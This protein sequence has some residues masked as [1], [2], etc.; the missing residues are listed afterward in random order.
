RCFPHIVNLACKAVVSA[1]STLDCKRDLSLSTTELAEA[2]QILTSD[3]ADPITI[4]RT[5]VRV[6]RAS[7]LRRQHF[8]Q[9]ARSLG[10]DLQLLRDVETR[11]SSTLYMIERALKLEEALNAFL[12]SKDFEDLRKYRLCEAEWAA[13]AIARE[14]LLVPD[15]FLQKLSSEKT[16]TLCNALPCFDAMIRVWT[17]Q[18]DNWGPKVSTIIQAGIDKLEVYRGRLAAVPAYAIAMGVFRVIFVFNLT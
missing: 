13:L 18:Q 15:A 4:L 2:A 9:F 14:I 3:R 5:L 8:S 7:S 6:V 12:T 1:F 10:L 17:D 16:P 11:W